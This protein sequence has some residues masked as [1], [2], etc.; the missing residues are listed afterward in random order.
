ML[1]LEKQLQSVQAE[2]QSVMKNNV[3]PGQDD[4]SVEDNNIV[5]ARY[6]CYRAAGPIVVDGRLNEASWQAAPMR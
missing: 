4:A 2:Y 5:P 3:R 1:D 6:T